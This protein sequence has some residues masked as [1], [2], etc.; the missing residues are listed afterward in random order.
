MNGVQIRVQRPGRPNAVATAGITLLGVAVGLALVNASLGSVHPERGSL[1]DQGE[2]ARAASAP[3]AA[4]EETPAAA[5]EEAPAPEPA[6]GTPSAAAPSAPTPAAAPRVARSDLHM[7]RGR[8]AYIRCASGA[9]PCPRDRALEARVWSA[10][11]ELSGCPGLAAGA[12]DLRLLMSPGVA[13]DVSFRAY[14]GAASDLAIAPLQACLEPALA[15][16]RTTLAEARY[17]VSFRFR[18]EA[19]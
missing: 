5:P 8:L 4:P 11:A 2:P 10:L 15:S 19:R 13:P 3:A 1:E 16:L 12:S 6:T 17:V 9:A 14:P 18:L 7:S